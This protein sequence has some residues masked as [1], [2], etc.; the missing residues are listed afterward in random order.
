MMSVGG[1]LGFGWL[2]DKYER[3]RIVA[4]SFAMMTAGLLFF[5]Y[6]AAASLW[7]LVPFLILF[8]FGYGG[9]TA[10]RPSI[11]AEY[12][13][14]ANYGTILGLVV[15]INAIGGIVGP[16]LAGWVFDTWDSYQGVWLAYSGLA[17]V[18]SLLIVNVTRVKMPRE[19]S[20]P[21]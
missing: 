5:G 21:D 17:V 12:F 7:L 10:T 9:S 20:Q 4:I 19:D 3:R 11:V 16:P 2:G 18:A 1:R 15:G 14:R 8:G 13:G 6:A